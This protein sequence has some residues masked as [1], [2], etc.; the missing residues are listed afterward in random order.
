M[1]VY[2]A[3]LALLSYPGEFPGNVAR[4]TFESGADFNHD[5]LNDIKVTL[6]L[7]QWDDLAP[8]SII[9]VAV[10]IVSEELGGWQL[11]GPP[12]VEAPN[13][14][15]APLESD[16]VADEVWFGQPYDLVFQSIATAA[17]DSSKVINFLIS[18]PAQGDIPG[19][20]LFPE[21]LLDQANWLIAVVPASSL[22]QSPQTAE[23]TTD[24]ID[25]NPVTE[26]AT[27]ESGGP[28]DRGSTDPITGLIIT[29]SQPSPSPETIIEEASFS[30][31]LPSWPRFEVIP[32]GPETLPLIKDQR[33]WYP[34]LPT[35][36]TIVLGSVYGSTNAAESWQ[37]YIDENTAKYAYSTASVSGSSASAHAIAFSG[38]LR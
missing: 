34:Q 4:L 32:T 19:E 11:F 18:K 26:P 2:T 1:L 30:E 3:D 14:S 23:F 38:T 25:L 22:D 10:D 37:L 13:L 36:G 20:D 7:T 24:F 33:A 21:M 6:D 16:L 27:S 29:A 8:Q 35:D 31:P 9:T 5:G 15:G 17:G 28:K 12:Q